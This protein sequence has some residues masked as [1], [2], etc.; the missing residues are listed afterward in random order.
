MDICQ[1]AMRRL[2]SMRMSS[3][4]CPTATFHVEERRGLTVEQLF[5]GLVRPTR[6]VQA[7]SSY[8][9]SLPVDMFSSDSEAE[10][11]FGDEAYDAA[12][13]AYDEA[14]NSDAE[15]EPSAANEIQE[16]T[17]DVEEAEVLE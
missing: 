4:A 17:S 10:P 3:M 14:V 9:I 11:D 16:G 5:R 7:R 15:Q 6:L 12:G 13:K 1:K 2:M 8:Q